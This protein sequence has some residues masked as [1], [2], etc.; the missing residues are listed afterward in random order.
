MALCSKILKELI[1][2]FRLYFQLIIHFFQLFG[3]HIV[4]CFTYVSALPISSFSS[5]SITLS[6]FQSTWVVQKS[7]GNSSNSCFSAGL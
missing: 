6:R 5:S 2:M 7:H 1:A 4:S 3:L